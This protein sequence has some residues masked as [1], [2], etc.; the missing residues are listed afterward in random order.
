MWTSMGK[1]EPIAHPM[2]GTN[3][4]DSRTR[5][6]SCPEQVLWN[7]VRILGLHLFE[8]GIIEIYQ[9]WILNYRI[10]L[11]A[12]LELELWDFKLGFRDCIPCEIGIIRPS[13]QGPIKHK[14]QSQS[15]LYRCCRNTSLWIDC[16][17]CR[18]G[19]RLGVH[20]RVYQRCKA[21]IW[22]ISFTVTLTTVP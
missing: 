9:V 7:V 5:D 22:M 3:Q 17:D 1:P 4:F 16:C 18:H 20:S 21:L 13:Y 14:W 6:K 2:S 10:S 15:F 11:D 8:F 12:N 19:R